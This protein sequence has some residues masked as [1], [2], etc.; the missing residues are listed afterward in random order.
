M[1]AKYILTALLAMGFMAQSCQDELDIEKKGNLGSPETYYTTDAEV[2]AGL[3]MCYSVM[4]R[5][6]RPIVNS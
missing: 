5:R 1:K 2:Q 3:A 6:M 4:L